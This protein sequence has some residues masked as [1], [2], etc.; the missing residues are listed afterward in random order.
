MANTSFEWKPLIIAVVIAAGTAGMTWTYTQ[1]EAIVRQDEAIHA[2]E[3]EVAKIWDRTDNRFTSSDGDNL[4][5]R[6][7][8]LE[9]I[10]AFREGVESVKE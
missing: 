4:R 5:H 1:S 7:I 6:I 10:A 2:L 9:K 3:A 8:E